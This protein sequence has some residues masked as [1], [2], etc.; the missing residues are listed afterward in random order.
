MLVTEIHPS[1]NFDSQLGSSFIDTRLQ[2]CCGQELDPAT[3]QNAPA[4]SEPTCSSGAWDVELPDEAPEL[5]ANGL[6]AMTFV[7]VAMSDSKAAVEGKPFKSYVSERI[8]VTD[9]EILRGI[10]LRESLR[11]GGSLWRKN[12]E[13]LP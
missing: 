9:T 1:C 10:T 13:H 3:D 2:D 5:V 12:P 6:E 8:R 4:P 7:N 11:R